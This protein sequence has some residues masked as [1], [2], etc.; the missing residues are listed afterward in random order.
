LQNW[1][2]VGNRLKLEES[3]K[4]DKEESWEAE[5]LREKRMAAFEF[6]HLLYNY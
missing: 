5:E 1:K 2:L 6:Q 4:R 3:F